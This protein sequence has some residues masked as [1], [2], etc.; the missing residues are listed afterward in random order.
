MLRL[1][2]ILMIVLLSIGYNGYAEEIQERIDDFFSK[3]TEKD[4]NIVTLFSESFLKQVPESKIIE[5]RNSFTKQ[6]GNF[7]KAVW[8][9]G[10]KIEVFYE[11]CTM[12]SSIDFDSLGLVTALWFGVP[13]FKQ[14][15]WESIEEALNKISGRVS[16]CIRKDGSELFR[17]NDLEPLAIG[18]TFKLYVL[19]TLRDLADRD[20][21]DIAD[22]L[23]VTDDNKSLP[24]GILH[25]SKSGYKVS[26]SK[27][28]ELMISISD[29]TA[30]DM[31]IDFV[32]RDR[33]E[34]TAPATMKPF[35][36]TRELFILKLGKDSSYVSKFI[37]M[38]L[39]NKYTALKDLATF[40][41]SVLN[42]FDFVN[43]KF[44]EIEWYA[45]TNELCRIIEQLYG[46]KAISINKALAKNQGW[47]YVGYKGGSE[48]GVLNLTFL[49]KKDASAPLISL[50]ATV[51]N[52]DDNVDDMFVVVI[53][54]I[55]DYLY[56]KSDW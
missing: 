35:Y 11:K 2:S 3:F 47:E 25:M 55:L 16:L 22:S 30:T 44:M 5:I 46:D 33:I 14:D 42:P 13:N 1:T 39:Q 41:L 4:Y 56:S 6:Y 50:S 10:K 37:N 19:K 49:L 18:S 36:K 51:N 26:I 15:S 43:P 23:E 31:L 24:S 53:Q 7:E 34:Q 29:N 27:A 52:A 45:N 17:L 40:D 54:R 12:P 48:P 20:D 8:E 9:S 21:I 28:A 38:D 32:G